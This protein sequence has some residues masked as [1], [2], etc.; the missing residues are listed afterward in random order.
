MRPSSRVEVHL[1]A[2]SRSAR[3]CPASSTARRRCSS[4]HW[5]AHVRP[6]QRGRERAG[7]AAQQVGAVAHVV[8]LL[9]QLRPARTPAAARRPSSRSCSRS[10]PSRSTAWS[11]PRA[12]SARS[13]PGR[14]NDGSTRSTATAPSRNPISRRE[15]GKGVHGRSTVT[16]STEPG[17]PHRRA[18]RQVA[19][20][21]R[22]TTTGAWSLAPVPARSS[23]STKAPVTRAAKRRV[24]E[25]EVDA[26]ALGCARSAA[27]SSPS[28]CRPRARGEGAHHVG[29]PVVEEGLEGRALRRRSRACSWRTPPCRRRP[30]PAA[31][32]SSRRPAPRRRS[33]SWP[34]RAAAASQSSL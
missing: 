33:S 10:S 11:S 7:L 34:P 5:P 28:R 25:H 13:M 27:G 8:D 29:V 20:Q 23:R 26:H 17:R 9:A 2:R 30:R 6:A 12:S 19:R 14:S 32:C 18:H 15:E 16:G 21:P 22:S 31:R 4:P 3:P 24:A 1:L